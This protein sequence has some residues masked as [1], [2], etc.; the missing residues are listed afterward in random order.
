MTTEVFKPS[1]W[2]SSSPFQCQHGVCV[3]VNVRF[4]VV[5]FEPSC[6]G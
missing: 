2:G 5:T 1:F 4:K 6:G 3:G